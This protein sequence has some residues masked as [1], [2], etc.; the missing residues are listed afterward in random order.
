M[1]SFNKVI[2]MGNITRDPQTRLL[3]N[4]DIT[5][6]EFG[7]AVNEGRGDKER[8]NFFDCTAFGK[9]AELITKFFKKGRPI[10]LDGRLKYDAW[11]ADGVKRS[12]VSVIAENFSFVDSP[13]KDESAPPKAPQKAIKP[14]P[15]VEENEPF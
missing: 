9:M 5:V 7:I 14:Q 2:L 1:A 8:A 3:P 11:E 13:P 10:L 4:S 12:R 6:C 15:A